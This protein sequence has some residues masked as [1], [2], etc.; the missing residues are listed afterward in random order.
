MASDIVAERK[1]KEQELKVLAGTLTK[2]NKMIRQ[3]AN[4][5]LKTQGAIEALK[6]MEKKPS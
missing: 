3:T 6:A 2:L 4:D 5:I 1:K